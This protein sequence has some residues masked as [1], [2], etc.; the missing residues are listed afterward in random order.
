MIF[1][2]MR[3]FAIG[4]I[5]AVVFAASLPRAHAQGRREVAGRTYQIANSRLTLQFVEK[6][7]TVKIKD[8]RSGLE[9]SEASSSAGFRLTARPVAR[10]RSLEL[11]LMH[12]ETGFS[13]TARYAFDEK[14]P[15]RP[16]VVLTILPGSGGP[17]AAM[18]KS[19]YYPPPILTATGEQL[20]LPFNEGMLYPV[21][22]ISVEP[23]VY[24]RFCKGFDLS[25]RWMGLVRSA[26]GAGILTLLETSDDAAVR[27][28]RRRAHAEG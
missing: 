20:V 12:K 23:P 10:A 26:K 15:E 16:E 4:L 9:W 7:G 25:M 11:K 21:D 13:F 8:R 28:E 22:D 1:S 3:R 17:D 2:R 6:D 19:L 14:N 24:L 27:T 5:P 18:A